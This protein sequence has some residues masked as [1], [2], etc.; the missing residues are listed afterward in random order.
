MIGL[1]T[2]K[3]AAAAVKKKSIDIFTHKQRHL[4]IDMKTKIVQHVPTI[5]ISIDIR[6]VTCDMRHATCDI[7]TNTLF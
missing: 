4:S 3:G 5:N 6:H 7:I 1:L 2:G